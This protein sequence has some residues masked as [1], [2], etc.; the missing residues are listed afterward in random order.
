M[1]EPEFIQ[2]MEKFEFEI[3][4]RNSEDTRRY[5]EEAYV[6]IGKMIIDLKIPKE[7]EKK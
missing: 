7:K 5:L 3:T 2:T 6:R 4:Y 1:D